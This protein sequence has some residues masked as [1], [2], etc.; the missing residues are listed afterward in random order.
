MRWIVVLIAGLLLYFLAWPVQ[1]SPESWIAPQNL[2]LVDPFAPNNRLQRMRLIDLQNHNGP[3]DIAAGPDGLLYTGTDDGNIIRLDSAGTSI[4]VFAHVGGRP[5]GLEFSATGDLVIAN[6]YTGLQV[7]RKDGSVETLVDEYAGEKI[8]YADDVAI[9][10][11]GLIYFSDAS[12]KHGAQES[13]GTYAASLIDL[14][15]HGGHGRVFQFNPEESE[16]L[17]LVDGLNFANGVAVSEDQ[18]YLLISETG[19][20][21]ILRYWLAG[22]RRG[23]VDIVIDNLPGF[24]DNINTGRSGKFWIGLVAPRNDLLDR[25]STSPWLRKLVQRLPAAFRPSAEA[26]SHIIAI[27]GD[28][29]VLMNLQ[30]G[31]AKLPALT[32]VYESRDALWASSLFGRYVGQLD[33]A[34]LAN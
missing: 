3:E 34:D 8:K 26:S 18:Q 10:E 13:G 32:G 29:E 12:S 22:L 14:M 6:A 4:G 16:I 1:V 24:P 9:A 30:D 33:K 19:S 17:L 27:T 23:E 21:R 2:G 28:G 20:Y 5:L 15:E 11:N 25:L 31:R 7:V